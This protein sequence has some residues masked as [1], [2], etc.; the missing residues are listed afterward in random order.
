MLEPAREAELQL[1][2]DSVHRS[3]RPNAPPERP[4]P[5][6]PAPPRAEPVLVP[7]S[8]VSRAQSER[9]Q[10]WHIGTK[11]LELLEQAYELDSFPSLFARQRLA[12]E[13]GVSARQVQ[14]WFQNR[15]RALPDI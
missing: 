7:Y 9:P 12:D 8:P 5:P 2:G 15:R 1:D 4:T 3:A 6:R 11:A 10:R 13:M 14:V